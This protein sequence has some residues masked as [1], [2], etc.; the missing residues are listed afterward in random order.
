MVHY[1]KVAALCKVPN[2]ASQE[3]N[4][5]SSLCDDPNRGNREDKIDEL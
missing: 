1:I 5:S 2:R 3:P 4:Q